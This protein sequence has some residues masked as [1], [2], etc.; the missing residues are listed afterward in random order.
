MVME[1]TPEQHEFRERVRSFVT[2]YLP[3][4]SARKYDEEM[5]FPLDI[6]RELARAGFLGTAVP[7][8]YGGNG[9]GYVDLAILLEELAKGMMSFALM[10]FRSAVHGAQTIL[11]LDGEFADEQRQYYLPRI[12][13][14]EAR[15]TLSLSEYGA[16]SD[17][18]AVDHRAVADGDDF[19][20]NGLK[21]FSSALDVATHIIVVTRTSTEGRRYDGLSL[22]LVPVDSAGL[23][24]T[25]LYGLGDR[26]SGTWDVQ[27]DDV[28]VPRS[29]VLGGVNQG[30]RHLMADLEKERLCQCAYSAGGAQSVLDQSIAHAKNREQFGGPIGRFQFVQHTLADMATDTHIGRLLLYDLARRLDAGQ[31]CD[32]RSIDGQAVLHGD[33]QPSRGSRPADPRRRRLYDGQ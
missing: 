3:P 27:Y 25:R 1:F 16:G 9:G 26:A 5:R 19:V 2:E 23:A 6:Y 8:E 31:R 22:I 21:H 24:K 15:F 33:V 18:A 4:G 28:R 7:K 12:V 30:W 10:T 11:R 32:L 17:A 14:G 29:E 13:A 20:L